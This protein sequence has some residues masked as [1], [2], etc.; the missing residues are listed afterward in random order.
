MTPDVLAALAATIYQ[1]HEGRLS[2]DR[3][4][5]DAESLWDLAFE[6]CKPVPS[7]TPDRARL[8]GVV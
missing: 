2:F 7:V 8:A 5:D 3:C 4:L 6:R 1:A